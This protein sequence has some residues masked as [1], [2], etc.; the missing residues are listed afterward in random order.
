VLFDFFSQEIRR[1]FLCHL[2]EDEQAEEVERIKAMDDCGEQKLTAQDREAAARP[3]E[4]GDYRKAWDGYRAACRLF[5][6]E[7][8]AIDRRIRDPKNNMTMG[9]RT[10]LLRQW[11]RNLPKEKKQEGEQAAAKWNSVGAAD[12]EKQAA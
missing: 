11:W 6:D 8:E 2:D 5:P 4:A 12:K 1:E 7:V 9:S 3:A 10:Q